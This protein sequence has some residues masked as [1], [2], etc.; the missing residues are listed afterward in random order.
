MSCAFRLAL[1]G[2]R[3]HVVRKAEKVAGGDSM[4]VFRSPAMMKW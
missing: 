4:G 1:S 3:E 2:M